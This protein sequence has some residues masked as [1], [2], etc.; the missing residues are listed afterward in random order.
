M[1]DMD[2][3]WVF[4]PLLVSASSFSLSYLFLYPVSCGISEKKL[5]FIYFFFRAET[6]ENMLIVMQSYSDSA[7]WRRQQ[8]WQNKKSPFLLNDTP[9]KH[10]RATWSRPGG[11]WAAVKMEGVYIWEAYGKVSKN[12]ENWGEGYSEKDQMLDIKQVV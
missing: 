8:W 3:A 2:S 9:V 6:K 1:A 12:T 10:C 4:C 11:Y 7:E 5:D